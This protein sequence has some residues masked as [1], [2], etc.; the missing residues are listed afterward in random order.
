MI[1]PMD[2][3]HEFRLKMVGLQAAERTLTRHLVRWDSLQPMGLIITNPG[4]PEERIETM[5]RAEDPPAIRQARLM[6]QSVMQAQ[7]EL[8][9]KLEVMERAAS[10]MIR[11][12]A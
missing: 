6:L 7:V 10:R 11:T 4:T 8:Q 3:R 5:P 12:R 2:R 1:N 9:E